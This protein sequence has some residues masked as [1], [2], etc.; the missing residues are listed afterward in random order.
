MEKI[1]SAITYPVSEAVLAA[2]SPLITKKLQGVAFTVWSIP[3]IPINLQGVT[4]T[5]NPSQLALSTFNSMMCISG[6][7][8]VSGDT[9]SGD[10]LR[11]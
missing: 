8:T 5:L 7:V 1:L 9:E 2:F 6:S 3:S 4:V 11:P 10:R